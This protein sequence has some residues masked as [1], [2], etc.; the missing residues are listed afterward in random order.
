MRRWSVRRKNAKFVV[1][2]ASPEGR[3][4]CVLV[5]D[6]DLMIAAH[7]VEQAEDTSA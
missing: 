3:F 4:V 2:V 5:L 1:P 6:S 7:K